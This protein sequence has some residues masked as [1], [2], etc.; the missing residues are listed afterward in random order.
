MGPLSQQAADRTSPGVQRRPEV[1]HPTRRSRS[2]KKRLLSRSAA[3]AFP[4]QQY[5]FRELQVQR[6]RHLEIA[7]IGSD[8]PRQSG[9]ASTA[10]ALP[11]TRRRNERIE[12]HPVAE[13]LRLAPAT[14]VH[15]TRSAKCG[16]R[17][18]HVSGCRHREYGEQ[19]AGVANLGNQFS[20]ISDKL[21]AASASAHGDPI[22]VDRAE[23]EDIARKP[24]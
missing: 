18:W 14:G 15:A 3:T 11:V 21:H 8:Q 24:L 9:D 20:T 22:L 5:P 10:P 6:I 4:V 17:P 13:H 16:H 7:G 19:S 1:P 12:Q 2:A 23:L